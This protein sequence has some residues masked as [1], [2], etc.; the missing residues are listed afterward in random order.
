MSDLKAQVAA[1]QQGI[2]LVKSLIDEYDLPTVQAY[3]GFIQQ[4][5]EMAVRNRR[6][7]QH[8]VCACPTPLPPA[9]SHALHARMCVV[10]RC[11]T[12]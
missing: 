9:T 7:S 10:N 12:C 1:N 8:C 11:E 6:R 4:N 5:A 3:M 2:R